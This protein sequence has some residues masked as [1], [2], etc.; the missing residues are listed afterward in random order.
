MSI[1]FAAGR[2]AFTVMDCGAGPAG[3][4]A[5][6]AGWT[7]RARRGV[8]SVWRRR[9]LSAPADGGPR[10]NPHAAGALGGR[11]HTGRSPGRV[12][13]PRTGRP[14]R[15]QVARR[16]AVCQPPA[17]P[18]RTLRPALCLA[19]RGVPLVSNVPFCP[20]F[21]ESLSNG[22]LHDPTRRNGLYGVEQML[23]LAART[24]VAP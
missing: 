13:T 14:R 2:R 7:P 16:A 21:V 12:V 5:G 15:S 11:L 24:D 10:C 18:W 22:K 17:R 19:P 3:A 8:G 23:R 9:H 20:A 1:F 6:A 4:G